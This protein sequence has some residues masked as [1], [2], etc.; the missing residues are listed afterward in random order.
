[1]PGILEGILGG[2]LI[3]G[4]AFGLPWLARHIV[5]SKRLSRPRNESY[6][7]LYSEESATL[8]HFGRIL[9][10][11]LLLV[12]AVTVLLIPMLSNILAAL[13]CGVLI[14][15]LSSAPLVGMYI[16]ASDLLYGE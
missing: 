10:V 1:M 4:T 5:I 11:H 12:T 13:G 8:K 3:M 9:V 16:G 7:S 14:L 2:I 15:L 6:E